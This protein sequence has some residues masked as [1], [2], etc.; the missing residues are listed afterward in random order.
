MGA[1]RKL[2]ERRD[3]GELSSPTYNARLLPEWNRPVDVFFG[4][5]FDLIF[6][7]RPSL[8]HLSS[9]LDYGFC[10]EVHPRALFPWRGLT[11]SLLVHAA[12]FGLLYLYSTGLQVPFHL[13]DSRS[14]RAMNQIQ[15]SPYLPELHGAA[16]H[17]NPGG[18]P[19]PVLARQEI[20]SVPDE[21]DNLSQTIVTPAPIKLRHDVELPN[22]VAYQPVLPPQSSPAGSLSAIL[23]T[24]ARMPEM[25][26]AA[27]IVQAKPQRA[28]ANMQQS[29]TQPAPEA[30]SVGGSTPDLSELV[31]TAANPSLPIRAPEI[32]QVRPQR[33]LSS[34]QPSVAQPAPEAG[35]INAESAPSL[36]QL[37]PAGENPALPMRAAQIVQAQ[38]QRLRTSVQ[39]QAV[40]AAPEIGGSGQG[41]SPNF[42][43]LL[44]RGGEPVAPAL[45]SGNAQA[46][47]VIAL[48]T[49][50]ADTAAAIPEGNR[51]GIFAA[52]PAGHANAT[53]APGAG[54][55]SGVGEHNASNKVN[56][57]PG[58]SV[59][60]PPA[61]A[62]AVAS[63]DGTSRKSALAAGA[64]QH[65]KLEAL[66][67][68]PAIA[69]LPPRQPVAQESSGPRNEVENHVF[70][71]RR[72][73]T[74]VVNMPNLNSN[75]G[76]WIIRYVDRAQGLA[77]AP[78][79]APEV[80]RKS[81][82]AY[83]GELSEGVQGTVILTAIIRADGSVSDIVVAKGLLPQLDQN[84]ADALSRWVFRP[85]LKDGQAIELEAVITVPFRR[86]RVPRF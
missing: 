41:T 51:R 71:G 6:G 68:T 46:G 85:A 22:M 14:F 11:D 54:E 23:Q 84:A 73:Y 36:S 1:I 53:G 72:S 21:P 37:V 39:P 3:V 57:P 78:I 67:R 42:A 86:N 20:R 29:V 18:K 80:V 64:G 7:R 34:K 45:Q 25:A 40:Q 33:V 79:T 58:I 44:P 13:V 76:S 47:Q 12:I 35:S 43:Q 66:T 59:A 63:P 77:A 28:F 10:R 50:P 52:S 55:S 16:T 31:P 56:A 8:A 38:P 4:N 81:D 83:P 69:P 27:A 74:L 2:R 17:R 49:H 65:T 70:A 9:A 32:V 15:L 61:P 60:A 30:G 5:L 19:D 75:V 24:P 82:P 26:P 48:S 62:T